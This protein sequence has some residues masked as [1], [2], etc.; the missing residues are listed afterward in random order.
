MVKDFML[1]GSIGPFEYFVF[2]A[3]A[4]VSNTYFYEEAGPNIRFF[5]RGNEITLSPE[6]VH[7][8]GT[9]GSFCEYMF[10][11]EKPF[12]DLIK[13]EVLN[14]LVM[15][16][17]FLD[18]TERLIFTN[19]TGGSEAFHRLFLLGHAVKNY[20]FFVSSDDKSEPRKRQRQILRSAGKF[21]KR[22]DLIAEDKEAEL[23]NGLVKEL[24][25]PRSTVFAFK[26]VHS[27]N[28]EYYRKFQTFYE[29]K[30]MLLPAEEAHLNAVAMKYHIDDYQQERM[31]IDSMYRH[32]ENKSIVDEYRDILLDIA[33]KETAEHSELAKLHRLRTL[34]IRNNI[35]GILF[36]TLD[37]LLLKDKDVPAIDEPEYLKEARAILENLFFKSPSL[38]RHIIREDIAKLI[39]AK[40][41]AHSHSDMGFERV[42]LDIG[43]ACDEFARE[44][45]D[46]GIFEELSSIIT[47][48]DRYDNIHTALSR[49][50]FMEHLELTENSLRSLVGNK[51]EFDALDKD[52]FK[53]IFV[54]ELL[55][56][57]YITAFGK[58]RI[59]VLNEG[60]GK[61]LRGDASLRDLVLELYKISEEER[62]YK[63][64]RASLKERLRELYTS[65]NVKEEM[66]RIRKEI[67][68]ELIR[69]GTA[70]EV[71]E[72]LF[73]K[74]LLDL[75]KESYYLNH[76][77]PV[78]LRDKDLA[79]REDF[80][81]NSGLDRFYIEGLEKNY[82]KDNGFSS[83]I[84]ASVREDQFSGAGG[85]ERI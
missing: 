41:I 40:H 63:Y 4:N 27:E 44:N 58:K 48:F 62:V 55:A 19:D 66:M 39:M 45:N 42:L 38:K 80:L 82:L 84:L 77:L 16:G 1:H 83:V 3:G 24:N 47:Y 25:E 11:V 12:K 32:R 13:K 73:D 65:L 75:K 64:I 68:A 34:S 33:Y 50:A 43:R 37:E 56:N 22:T 69:E 71:R 14:R 57:K 10:G 76:L 30:R 21:L 67:E 74:V 7:Y 49:I 23:V 54:K 36:D 46:F 61:V 8:K 52:L 81:N 31:K 78:I 51:K 15:F 28:L 85:G 18:E 79:L 72:N 35:P 60:I 59:K 6:G 70:W 5:S 29:D 17:A 2:V 53:N 9:G 20:Y 26:L